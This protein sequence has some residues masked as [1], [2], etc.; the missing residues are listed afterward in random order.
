MK[1][2]P[3]SM[4]EV[5]AGIPANAVSIYGSN[6]AMDDFPVLKAFQQYIDDEHSKARKRLA[7]ICF[8]FGTLMLVVV[9]VFVV[10]LL[11]ANV[12]NQLLN[13]RLVEF[14]MRDRERSQ[15]AAVP[16]PAQDN[17]KILAAKIEELQQKIVE[18]Q[19]RAEKL[20]AEMSAQAKNAAI[21]ASKPKKPS[22]EELEVV[23]L[24]TLLEIEKGKNAAAQEKRR[25]EE[26]EAYRRA[27]YPELYEK[28]SEKVQSKEDPKKPAKAEAKKPD[29]SK[30]SE[31]V[32]EDLLD[33]VDKILAEG[34]ALRYY[35][36][37]DAGKGATNSPAA[38]SRV[39]PAPKKEYSIPVDIRGSSGRWNIPNE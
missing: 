36:E 28:K 4:P 14:A 11:N 16:V 32:H 37:T 5:D 24:K 26:L 33:E 27:H 22:P 29:E 2:N 19:S 1:T 17:S 12:R 13:D 25:Q 9:A 8:F 31:K 30:S 23:R 15:Q 20:A 10:L 35:D 18:S 3:G 39:N 21:E 6:D 38:P 34:E 7:I